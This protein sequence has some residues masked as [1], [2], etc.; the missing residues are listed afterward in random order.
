[1]VGE[2]CA[3]SIKSLTMIFL[4]LRTLLPS[5]ELVQ[6][7]VLPHFRDIVPALPHNDWMTWGRSV[8]LSGPQFFPLNMVEMMEGGL[9]T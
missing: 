6:P 4:W 3:Y 9:W 2:S 7:H 5:W 8:H 1:M